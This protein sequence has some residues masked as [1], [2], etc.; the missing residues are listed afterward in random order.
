[1]VRHSHKGSDCIDKRTAATDDQLLID[2][3][4]EH[5]GFGAFT[6]TLLIRV[7][8]ARRS[9]RLTIITIA[10]QWETMDDSVFFVWF[11]LEWS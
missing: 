3:P 7:D 2:L 4:V 10:D 11:G 6:R 9:R 8:G 1:V 5:D